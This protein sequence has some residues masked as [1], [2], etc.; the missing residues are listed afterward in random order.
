MDLAQI[1]IFAWTILTLVVAA[2]LLR[3]EVRRREW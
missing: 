1:S 2:I 3:Y